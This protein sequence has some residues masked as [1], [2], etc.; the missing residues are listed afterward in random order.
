MT[1]ATPTGFVSRT[2]ALAAAGVLL[3]SSAWAV[4]LLEK[5]A[6]QKQRADIN[7]QGA[8]YFKCIVKA[9]LKCEKSGSSSAQ[10]CKPNMPDAL[11]TPSADFGAAVQSCKD[12]I[13]YGKKGSGDLIADYEAIGCPGDCDAATIGNQRCDDLTGMQA[14]QENSIPVSVSLLGSILPGYC[15][16]DASCVAAETTG[17]TEY[18]LGFFACNLACENDYK[19]KKGN[20]GPTDSLTQCAAG[21]AA[22]APVFKT[23]IEAAFVKA[24]SKGLNFSVALRPALHGLLNPVLNGLYNTAENCGD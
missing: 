24:Q 6:P 5:S 1:F 10:E 17:M 4:V 7:K 11:G 3:S 16:L 14:I 12:K 18:I 20:G 19:N 8:A 9:M 21:D 15:G 13:D 2:L 23:C 22:A